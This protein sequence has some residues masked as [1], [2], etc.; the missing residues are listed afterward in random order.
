M[1]LNLIQ[2]AESFGVSERVVEDWIRQHG[3]P[4]TRDRSRILF[5]RALVANWAASHGLAARTGF[6]APK[7]GAFC[8]REALAPMLRVGRIWRDVPGPKVLEV[9][10]RMIDSIPTLTPPV[11][12]MLRQRLKMPDGI[13]WAP[14]GEGIALPHFRARV[15]LGRGSGVIALLALRDSLSQ[16]TAA[17]DGVPITRLFFFI[18]PSP[19]AHLDMLGRMSRALGSPAFR[20]LVKRSASDEAI[21]NAVAAFDRSAN[22]GERE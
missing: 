10:E 22:L 15:T 21:L 2:V 16:G 12:L 17:V 13:N 8:H 5:D 3:L 20:E 1:Y 6:L 9:L 14:V 11:K 18:P 7:D 4:H 19:R